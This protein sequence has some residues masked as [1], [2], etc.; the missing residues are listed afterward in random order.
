MSLIATP[1]TRRPR[2][3]ALLGGTPVRDRHAYLRFGQPA[4]TESDIE[5]VV[6]TLRSG[7]IGTGP[8]VAAFEAQFAD[9]VGMPH[10]V[11][12]SS[13]T[14]ALRLAMLAGGL[15][16]GDEV[17]TTPL[18]FCATVNSILHCGAVPVLAD[19]RRDDMNLDPDQVRARITPRTKAILPV[20]F[21]GRLC[22]MEALARIADRH[23]LLVLED[24]A[25]AIETTGADGR[26]AG[27]YG[28]LGAFSFY[29]TKNITTAE[30]GM[31]VTRSRKIANR[32]RVLALHGMSKDAWRRFSDKGYKHYDIVELGYK[33]NMTDIQASL[34]LTQLARVE[35]NLHKRQEI[36]RRYDEAFADLP[37]ELPAPV[38]QGTRHARHLYT[39]LVDGEDG[40]CRDTVLAALHAE[41]IGAGVHYLPLNGYSY[42]Q[43]TLG[44]KPGDFPNAE[45]IGAR[46][47]S[48]PLS[49]ALT[50]ED[51]EDVV[52]SVRGV[53]E[54]PA[55]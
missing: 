13:C 9:Y 16:P 39:V 15:G 17:V 44:V 2:R 3:P 24:C 40:P 19:C 28:D 27:A 38:P 32:L 12:L 31:V 52:A 54:W 6:D 53:L 33:C 34:G 21:G 18:T 46:T 51:V 25:H 50:A 7:W 36:W 55:W 43:K 22:D 26:H 5:A 37:L 45:A 4:L 23:G 41:G 14:S 29:A 48:L 8:K 42:Y 30:G 1:S 49:P 35:W 10:A 11:A 47:L 20:H